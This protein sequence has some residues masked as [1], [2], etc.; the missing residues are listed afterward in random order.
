MTLAQH[1]I[2]TRIADEGR[3]PLIP[4][5]HVHEL[6]HAGAV[7][8]DENVKVTAALVNHPPIVPAFGYRFDATDRSIVISGDTAR[9]ESLVK[10]A[11][12]AEVLVHTA[13]YLPAL[14]RLVA[15]VPNA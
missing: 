10:L 5:V 3:I 14:D 11:Q 7:M 12:G 6:I 1:G 4:L 9:S 15:R 8:Q 13:A 2:K